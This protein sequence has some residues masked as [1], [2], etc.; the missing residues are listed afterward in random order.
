MLGEVQQVT[1]VTEG[2]LT[3]PLC[4]RFV[5]VSHRRQVELPKTVLQG[6]VQVAWLVNGMSSLVS[7]N[8]SYID[9]STVVITTSIARGRPRSWAKW[10]A[11]TVGVIGT[12]HSRSRPST[13]STPVSDSLA[14]NSRIRR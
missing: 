6:I 11:T 5:L 4:R 3:S 8:A 2:L 9:K 7:S 13:A 1:F 12:F 14:A 10:S